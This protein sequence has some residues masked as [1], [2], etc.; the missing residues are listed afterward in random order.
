MYQAAFTAN[1]RIPNV[2]TI[3]IFNTH[4]LLLKP[5]KLYHH[6]GDKKQTSEMTCTLYNGYQDKSEHI[7]KRSVI[8][9]KS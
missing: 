5:A 2:Y 4:I 1:Q 3:T 7:K 6:S 9:Q 8:M